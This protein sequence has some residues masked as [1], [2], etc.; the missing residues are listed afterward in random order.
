[1]LPKR[2]PGHCSRFAGGQEGGLSPGWIDPTASRPTQPRSAPPPRPAPRRLD[3]PV[4]CPG[5]G[6]DRLH[7]NQIVRA[8]EETFRTGFFGTL[9]GTR[10]I[11]LL[12]EPN[13]RRGAAMVGRD[14]VGS[15]RPGYNP[16]S[17]PPANREHCSER[18][19]GSKNSLIR[20]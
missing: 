15:I 16:P 7:T 20:T 6:F 10:D 13:R 1:M 14:A 2:R 9:V 4:V 18:F 5:F 19:F 11:C 8:S 12:G 17:S 3:R